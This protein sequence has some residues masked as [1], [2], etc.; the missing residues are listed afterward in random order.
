LITYKYVI[1][2]VCTVDSHL[3][4]IGVIKA[5]P[6]CVCTILIDMNLLMLRVQLNELEGQGVLGV[7]S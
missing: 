6:P 7:P 5:Y 2:C 4:M 3:L 1:L